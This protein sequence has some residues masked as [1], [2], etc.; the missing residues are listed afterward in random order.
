MRRLLLS[1]PIWLLGG[2]TLPFLP[3]GLEQTAPAEA[4]KA[5]AESVAELNW[6]KDGA[7]ALASTTASR[8]AQPVRERALGSVTAQ[9]EPAALLP[10]VPDTT[11]D[12]A[13]AGV[14]QIGPVRQTQILL[15][16]PV[17]NTNFP[18]SVPNT[19]PPTLPPVGT[20]GGPPGGGIPP[21]GGG[22]STPPTTF[23]TAT[24]LQAFSS[25][26]SNLFGN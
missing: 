24:F 10:A 6:G 8:D 5:E 9:V 14:L 18:P 13:A 2:C 17:P 11:T 26:L 19:P 21:S 22:G 12:V 25:S 16:D 4:P 3:F 23:P 20:P 1:L 7:E 15:G